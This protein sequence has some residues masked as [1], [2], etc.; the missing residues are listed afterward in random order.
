MA[1][2]QNPF[3]YGFSPWPFEDEDVTDTAVDPYTDFYAGVSEPPMGRDPT[4]PAVTYEGRTIEDPVETYAGNVA[5]FTDT[6]ENVVSAGADTTLDP[7]TGL[8]DP[9][10]VQSTNLRNLINQSRTT[11]PMNL[12]GDTLTSPLVPQNIEALPPVFDAEQAWLEDMG[13]VGP[14]EKMSEF[15]SGFTTDDEEEELKMTMRDKFQAWLKKGSQATK[16]ALQKAA[17]VVAP[18]FGLNREELTGQ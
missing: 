18:N 11:I 2:Y 15:V 13:L 7:F 6:I 8:A 4:I 9:A 10:S 3:L 16:K 12:A 1:T 14:Y 5:P 17:D